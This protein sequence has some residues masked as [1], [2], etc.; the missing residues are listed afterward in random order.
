MVSRE[1]IKG[2]QLLRTLQKYYS[3]DLGF[4]RVILS[5][6]NDTDMG[7]VL[8]NVVYFELLRRRNTV[9]IGKTENEEVDFIAK[10]I[11][12]NEKVYYQVAYTAKETSTLKREL[13]PFDKIGDHN[14]KILL[15]TD[16]HS[17]VVNGIKQQNVIDCYSG[18]SYA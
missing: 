4:R 6:D 18:N 10:N 7:H 11:D 17:T 14:Q 2:K 3:V 15:T 5:S 12:S 13:R 9:T 8:E 16:T 1:D